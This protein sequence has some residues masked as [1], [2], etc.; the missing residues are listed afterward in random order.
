M[1]FYLTLSFLIQLAVGLEVTPLTNCTIETYLTLVD[2]Q[3]I[4]YHKREL[5]TSVEASMSFFVSPIVSLK[6]LSLEWILDSSA[7]KVVRIQDREPDREDVYSTEKL[8]ADM[9][10]AIVTLHLRNKG[11]TSG[12]Y[13]LV[14][15]AAGSSAA[16]SAFATAAP[17]LPPFPK[18][19]RVLEGDVLRLLC[20]PVGYPKPEAVYWSFS[21]L[22]VDQMEDN[23]AIAA[24]E[25]QL[26]PLEANASHYK[27]Q[28]SEGGVPNDTLRFNQLLMKD[29]GLYACNVSNI[30]GSDLTY[31][32]VNVKD[33]WAALW[34][35]IGIVIEVTV[36]VTAILLYERHQMRSKPNKLDVNAAPQDA[37]SP[38]TKPRA[39]GTV[40]QQ[41]CA[42]ADD[43]DMSKTNAIE[44]VDQKID[45]IR[46]RGAPKC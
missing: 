19:K 35:F 45:E 43:A 39:S 10:K 22:G 40:Q 18:T 46:Q 16:G 2:F 41:R 27:L 30:Y 24:A 34:P 21:A 26:G 8:E 25:N 29:N 15:H 11:L 42:A 7:I 1:L 44:P 31:V 23:N 20:N 14:A 36:L 9:S 32:L 38:S 37:S 12:N 4:R 3:G 5:N 13:T 33:R 6:D 28:T 17:V